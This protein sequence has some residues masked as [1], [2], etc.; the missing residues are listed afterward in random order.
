MKEEL[1][2]FSGIHLNS[3]K[4]IAD[5]GVSSNY[6][7]LEYRGQELLASSAGVNGAA[8]HADTIPRGRGSHLTK[9]DL[10]VIV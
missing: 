2:S 5:K 8:R 1:K 6:T 3:L 9:L 4:R 7:Q 10:R